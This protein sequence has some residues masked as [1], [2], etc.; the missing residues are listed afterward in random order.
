[1]NV[2][3]HHETN[4]PYCPWQNKKAE[5]ENM[6][7][8]ESMCSMVHAQGLNLNLWGEVIQ[9]SIHVLNQVGSRTHEGVIAYELWTRR[10]LS[11]GYFKTFGCMT[12]AFMPKDL[13]KKLDPK[14]VKTIF[15][16]YSST[17]KAYKLWHPLKKQI[18]ICRDVLFQEEDTPKHANNNH[19]HVELFHVNM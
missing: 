12:Y 1:M 14:F 15:V 10:K 13:K 4:T 7:I 9:T 19:E 8:T 11:M 17:S 5:S 3:I 16:G 6:T 18:I 2:G